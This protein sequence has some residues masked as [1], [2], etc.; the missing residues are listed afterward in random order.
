LHDPA[1]RGFARQQAALRQP[2]EGLLFETRHRRRDGSYF[3]VEV[4][5]RTIDVEGRQFRHSIVRDITE[6]VEAEKRARELDEQL[7]RVG[8]ANELGQMMSS[9]AHELRQPLTAAMN[10]ANA[11]RRLLA[12]DP[13]PPAKALAMAEKAGEQIRRADLFVSD[14]RAFIQNR[15]SDY[16]EEE[17]VSIVDEIMPIALMGTSHLGLAVRSSHGEN[18]PRV[19]ADRIRVQQVLLNLLRNA[20]EAMS[21][22]PRR[23]LSVE[24]RL[25]SPDEV[26]IAVGDTGCGIP[27]DVAKRLFEP[28]VTSKTG[29]MGIGL[30]V[31]RSIIE[32]HGGRLW[33]ENRPEGGTI[34]RFTLPVAGD[35][36]APG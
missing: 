20:V 15:A 21:S 16:A 5:S 2:A 26:E 7:R 8:I 36:G 10:Y 12:T 24:T 18:L 25:S 34:F 33:A 14:L 28:F 13:A 35:A 30:P 11:C 3:P 17:I 27:P 9:I 19:C 23:E 6:R 4:S 29:G 31:C 22:A 32:A 1:A